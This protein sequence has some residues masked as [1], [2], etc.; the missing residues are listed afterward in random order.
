[1]WDCVVDHISHGAYQ[2]LIDCGWCPVWTGSS[3]IG[4]DS[5]VVVKL[6]KDGHRHM[7]SLDV[8][9][10][11][12]VAR[13][14]MPTFKM[15]A[16]APGSDVSIYSRRGERTVVRRAAVSGITAFSRPGYGISQP[17]LP[18]GGL[19]V[20]GLDVE[21]ST[22]YRGGDFPLPQ[23]SLLSIGIAT[24]DGQYLC[25]Y[26]KGYHIP[27]KLP[28]SMG[29]DV[30]RV[31]SSQ[32]LAD[33]AITWLVLECPDL[34]IVHNGYSYD[35][36][37]LAYHA[38]RMFGR[39]FREVSL[40]AKG[41]GYDLNIPGVTMVDTHR[42]LDKLHSQEYDYLSLDH[43]A[44][45]LCDTPKSQQ[46]PLDLQ[47]D[48]HADMTD[49]VFYNIHDAVLHVNVAYAS[50]CIDE[51][52]SACSVFK[53]PLDDVTRFVT[54][55]MVSML[56]ASH[57]VSSGVMIDWSEEEWPDAKYTGAM[58]IK[59]APGFYRDVYVLDVGAMYP[60][61]M[62][63]ANVSMETVEPCKLDVALPDDPA[64]RQVYTTMSWDD[65]FT[66][67]LADGMRSRTRK[68]PP[69]IVVS[70]LKH[71]VATRKRVGKKTPHGWA[72]K[73]GAN[74]VYGALGA[75][76]S[77]LQSYRGASMVTAIGRII[78][79]TA[80]GIAELMGFQVIYGDTDSV[81]ISKRQLSHITVEHYLATLH[82]VFDYMTLPSIR[83]ELEKEFKSFI[84]MGKKMYY[85]TLVKPDGSHATEVK[86]IAAVRK[87]RVQIAR[88]VSSAVCESICQLGPEAAIED[89]SEI[90]AE[91]IAS[92]K[93][94]ALPFDDM[95][96][97]VRRKGSSFVVYE[98]DAGNVIWLSQDDIDS[99][100]SFPKPSGD[101]VA[102]AISSAADPILEACGM[103]NSAELSHRLAARIM[104]GLI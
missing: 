95:T 88:T 75:S 48:S 15:T 19:R 32:E 1:M 89:V 40:G 61:V 38:S 25:R 51:L 82:L 59:P 57:A 101:Y 66:Y 34:V 18:S 36:R 94:G 74:S 33:W 69:G 97:S 58:V 103:P 63:D 102:K 41:K 83:L 31:E 100:K 4:P 99:K 47:Y 44:S 43:L 37:V 9:D 22:A 49:I 81:F 84:I 73:I 79:S 87:D 104:A 7:V 8:E 90:V 13:G 78:T 17:I 76:T 6:V 21:Q 16:I 27:S 98:D 35:I 56:L 64:L 55:T 2:S 72:L 39:Y 68:S 12:D 85:G 3:S 29:Y 71:L 67:V 50:K 11:D 92:A 5:R 70:A 10:D 26:V 46:P 93:L 45:T 96:R 23:D 30:S 52:M 62:V 14:L 80:A 77:K 24:S 54:G 42:Y 60:S 28:S 65:Q 91:A 86:G 20:V 53:S